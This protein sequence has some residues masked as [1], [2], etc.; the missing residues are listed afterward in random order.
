MITKGAFN[1]LILIHTITVLTHFSCIKALGFD[2]LRVLEPLV[3]F[4]WTA[5]VG[6]GVEAR[7]WQPTAVAT[8]R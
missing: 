2:M 7:G 4:V 1:F 5:M 6:G 8:A 3:K